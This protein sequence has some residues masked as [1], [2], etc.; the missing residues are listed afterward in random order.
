MTVSWNAVTNATSYDV[1]CGSESKTVTGSTTA[2]FTMGWNDTYEVEVVAKS[3]D[4]NYTDS[5]AGTTTAI[6]GA[7][8][9]AG[10]GEGGEK[11]ATI[12]FSSYSGTMTNGTIVKVDDNVSL[13]FAK[14]GGTSN[15]ALNSGAV[16]LYQNTSGN[17]GTMTVSCSS[18]AIK[19]IE[20]TYGSNM[21]YFKVNTG[22]LSSD[23]KTWTGDASSVIFTVNGTSS[24]QRAYV[25]SVTVTYQ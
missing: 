22:T 23:K 19:K 14:G 7:D 17:G 18:G 24:S 4:A 6:V 1:T 16:R 13:T 2:E 15:P 11:E 5:E 12:S 20:I 25:A 9:N 21:N 8:P 10:G 3:T